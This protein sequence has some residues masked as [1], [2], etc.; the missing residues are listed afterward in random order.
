[1]QLTL[2]WHDLQ[3]LAR[4][5]KATEAAEIAAEKQDDLKELAGMQACDL[6]TENPAVGI[7]ATEPHRSASP[8]CDMYLMK[9]TCRSLA[10]VMHPQQTPQPLWGM[11]SNV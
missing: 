6:L 8:S 1:M 7:S 11:K 2:L 5:L 9:L 10:D 4:Q 3:D